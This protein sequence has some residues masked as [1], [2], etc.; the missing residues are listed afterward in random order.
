LNCF[1][2]HW[3]SRYYLV[4]KL[5]FDFGNI[6][7]ELNIAAVYTAFSKIHFSSIDKFSQLTKLDLYFGKNNISDIGA[8]FFSRNFRHMYSVIGVKLVL[9]KNNINIAGLVYL[10]LALDKLIL[11]QLFLNFRKNIFSHFSLEML[12]LMRNCSFA[13]A[14]I[15]INFD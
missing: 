6:D 2:Q 7:I 8:K 3:L 10:T 15:D 9:E 5:N 1:Q 4:E 13:I 14:A 11:S 12:L